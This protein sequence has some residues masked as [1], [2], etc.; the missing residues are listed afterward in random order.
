[1]DIT[2]PEIERLIW[3][4]AWT[5]SRKCPKLDASDLAQELWAEAL[6]AEQGWDSEQHAALSTYLYPRLKWRALNLLKAHCV[7]AKHEDL[8]ASVHED[9][10]A[11]HGESLDSV[12]SRV[13]GKLKSTAA[14]VFDVMINPPSE[15]HQVAKEL[16]HFQQDLTAGFKPTVAPTDAHVAYFLGVSAMTVSRAM[17]Q[18]KGILE[19]EVHGDQEEGQRKKRAHC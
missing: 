19:Q 8:Y 18:I 17:K 3:W 2:C 14:Q 13:R 10:V 16:N 1:M 4:W 5:V 15:L 11:G 7:R 6:E 9:E 12:I